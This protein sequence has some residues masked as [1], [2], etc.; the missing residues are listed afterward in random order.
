MKET[1]IRCEKPQGVERQPGEMRAGTKV[2]TIWRGRETGAEYMQVAGEHGGEDWF[3]I[4]K[5]A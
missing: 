1:A 2:V 3:R 4:R 5:A